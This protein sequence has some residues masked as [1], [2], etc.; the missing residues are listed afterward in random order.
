MNF[1]SNVNLTR[2]E[3]PSDFTEQ[4]HKILCPVM[5]DFLNKYLT[6][7]I[8]ERLKGVGLLCGTDWTPFFKNNF[9][10]SR[11]DHSVG[12]A[13]IVWNFTHDKAQT[14]AGLLHDVSTPAFS[15]V[16][17]FRKG[18][19][20]TQTATEED[21]G[22]MLASSRELLD[23]L[24]RDG[25][26]LEQINDY[27]KYPIADNEVPQLSADRLEYMF[28]SGAA[29]AGTWSL[30]ESFTLDEIKQ[31]YNDLTICKNE[32]DIIELGFKTQSIAELYCRRTTDIALFLQKCEDKMA[33]QFPAEILNLAVKLNLL[34][35]E[36]FFTKSERKIIERLDSIVSDTQPASI[37]ASSEGGA[38]LAHNAVIGEATDSGAQ[39]APDAD[40]K[41]FCT[42]YKTYRTFTSITRS[43]TPLDGH[44][45]V[46][47]QVKKRYINPLV[48]EPGAETLN[49]ASSPE[50][51]AATSQSAQDCTTDARPPDNIAK[52]RRLTAISPEWKKRIDDFLS[53]SDAPYACVKLV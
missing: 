40:F 18:D 24:S 19:S 34:K 44:Y 53:Y 2:A 37:G 3:N 8:L 27:H 52:A 25:L 14:I 15:H 22:S 35:E 28:P 20:L 29:L 4:F 41:K 9:Y 12:V 43:D 21:N 30:T 1:N 36:D 47:I 17:D 13:L 38:T 23:C 33:M 31:I 51:G 7:P 32:D 6:L 16:A 11:F 50:P 45:C 10:Y 48:A 42:Y 26:T 49:A 46:N 5:P 39:S